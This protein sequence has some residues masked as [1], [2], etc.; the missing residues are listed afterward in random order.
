VRADQLASTFS[1][2]VFRGYRNA[3]YGQGGMSSDDLVDPMWLA[4]RVVLRALY[5]VAKSRDGLAVY[6]V[7]WRA[8]D[9]LASVIG[10]IADDDDFH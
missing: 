1:D 8:A 10:R 9:H 3:P 6:I 2:T 4:A 7:Q 5:Q